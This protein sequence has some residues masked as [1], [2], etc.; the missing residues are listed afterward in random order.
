MPDPAPPG[1]APAPS[2]GAPKGLLTT[3]PPLPPFWETTYFWYGLV[4]V[5]ASFFGL[6]MGWSIPDIDMPSGGGGGGR[7]SGGGG[8]SFGGK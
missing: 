1:P 6:L 4:I 5:G 7:S 8:W 2:P 3:P